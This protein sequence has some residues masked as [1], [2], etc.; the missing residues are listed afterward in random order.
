MYEHLVSHQIMLRRGHLY[1][2]IY[3]KTDVKYGIV[4]CSFYYQRHIKDSPIFYSLKAMCVGVI[5]TFVNQ[6]SKYI[7]YN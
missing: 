4:K 6:R 3:F 7:W 5:P 2:A 1:Y